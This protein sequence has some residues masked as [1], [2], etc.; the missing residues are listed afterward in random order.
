MEIFVGDNIPVGTEKYQFD[1][2]DT[3]KMFNFFEFSD[4]WPYHWKIKIFGF[5]IESSSTNVGL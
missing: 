1:Y 2:R 4:Y 5:A 3:S